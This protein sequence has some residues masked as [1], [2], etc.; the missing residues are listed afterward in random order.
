[1][2]FRYRLQRFMTGRYGSDNLSR[3]LSF[4]SLFLLFVS[5]FFRRLP[6]VYFSLYSVAVALIAWSIFRMFSRNLFSRRKENDTYLRVKRRLT[7][8]FK[9][10]RNMFRDR[11]TH[12]YYKCPNCREYVRITNPGR[13]RTIT[14]TCANCRKKFDKKT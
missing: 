1:M 9:L 12:R 3:F 2:N 4:F 10:L 13:G 7:K 5:L 11:K 6:T 14:I 8:K